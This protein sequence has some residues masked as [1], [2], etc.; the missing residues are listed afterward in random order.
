M[1]VHLR[2][3]N[4]AAALAEA[5]TARQAYEQGEPWAYGTWAQICI[6][7]GIAHLLA[8][9]VDGAVNELAPILRMPPEQRLTTLTTRLGD[10][11]RQ[12]RHRRYDG[13]TEVATLRQQIADYRA[14]AVTARALPPGQS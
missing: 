10:V 2:A 14:Q 4:P 5:E 11:D 1:G 8:G 9:R 7:S 3:G 6:G 13:S 12:L